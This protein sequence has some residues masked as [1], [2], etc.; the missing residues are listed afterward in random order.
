[1]YSNADMRKRLFILLTLTVLGMG[2]A[3]CR[4]EALADSVQLTF[5]LSLSGFDA[6]K[7]YS[8][9]TSVDKL[10][11]LVYD[12]ND[13]LIT[14]LCKEFSGDDF[15]PSGTTAVSV[16]LVK[17]QEYSFVFFA[18]K[19]GHY[20]LDAAEKTLL[21]TNPAGMMNDDGYDA[22]YARLTDYEVP[23]ASFTEPVVL[24]RPFAQINVGA[25]DYSAAETEGFALGSFQTAYTLS[26]PTTMNLLTGEV[27]A[28]TLVT[29]DLKAAPS[30][31][32]E[33]L[34][35]GGTSY[36]YLSMA[37]VLCAPAGSTADVT[38]RLMATVNNTPGAA[39]ARIF[40][41]I[42]L[43][44]NHRTN[45]LGPVLTSPGIITTGISTVLTQ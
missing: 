2:G 44:Q 17:D 31:S 39:R 24:K 7:A 10:S 25:T 1:M 3:S 28:S 33:T 21:V 15:T 45:I 29:A 26:I 32:S 12:R 14:E 20:T 16:S 34:T 27:G 13:V 4:R 19:D 38:F 36:G 30:V 35:V 23:S 37:Y 18:Q 9:G 22:F 8:D 6:T 40:S 11:F 43:R 5:E 41:S 42:P